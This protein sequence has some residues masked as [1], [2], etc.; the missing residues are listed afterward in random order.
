MKRIVM[1]GLMAASL[2]T[3]SC[4]SGDTQSDEVK[5]QTDSLG[6]EAVPGNSPVMPN[7]PSSVV[8]DDRQTNSNGNDTGMI[9]TLTPPDSAHKQ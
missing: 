6:T 7:S 5:E 2:L 4:N 1:I 9:D 3:F 8:P